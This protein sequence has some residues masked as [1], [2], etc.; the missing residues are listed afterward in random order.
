MG[1]GYGVNFGSS[2]WTRFELSPPVG[3]LRE[4]ADGLCF[5]VDLALACGAQDTFRMTEGFLEGGSQPGVLLNRR[6]KTLALNTR[7]LL[8]SRA[9]EE[10]ICRLPARRAAHTGFPDT[11]C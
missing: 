9:P 3:T 7:V 2:V 4:L 5:Q 8:W 10:V 11:A 6:A 1:V